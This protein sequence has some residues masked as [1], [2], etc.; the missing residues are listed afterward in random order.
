MIKVFYLNYIVIGIIMLSMFP[1]VSFS[2][3]G[4]ILKLLTVMC[5]LI[6]DTNGNTIFHEHKQQHQYNQITE[7]ILIYLPENPNEED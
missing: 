3:G 5:D 1:L 7:H 4:N 2:S 6:K